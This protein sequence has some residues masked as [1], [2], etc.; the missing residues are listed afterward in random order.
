VKKQEFK[1]GDLVMMFYVRH[2]YRAYKKLLLKWFGPFV[3]KNV[4]VDNG[5]YEFENVDGSPYPNHIN[6]DKLKKVLDM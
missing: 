5:S 1:K 3:I 2:H 6:H 4:F